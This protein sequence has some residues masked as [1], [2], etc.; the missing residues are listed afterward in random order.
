MFQNTKRAFLIGILAFGQVGITEAK[1]LPDAP[2]LRFVFEEL[3]DLGPD[4][5]AGQ[6]PKGGRNLIALLGGTVSGP[7]LQ[8]RV[9]A[10]GADWQLIRSDGCA[11]ILA[12]YFIKGDDGTLIHVINRGLGCPPTDRRGLY[13]RANPVF[14]APTGPHD[15]LNRSVFTSTIEEMPAGGQNNRQVRVRFYEIE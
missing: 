11:E 12:D 5:D 15:W 10:G 13:L 14:D 1:A 4:E 9:V 7:R 3:V 6:G 2:Q 8:G